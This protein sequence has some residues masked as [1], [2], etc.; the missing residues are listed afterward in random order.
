MPSVLITAFEPYEEWEENSSWLALIELT[1]WFDSGGRVTT[2]RYPANFD[3][4]HKRLRED[5]RAEY[6][7]MLHL[8]Q[9]PG[10]PVLTLESVGLNLRNDGTALFTG[11]PVA[12]QSALPLTRWESKLR[13]AGIPAKVSHHAGTYLC[14]ATLFATHHLARELGVNTQAAFIHVPLAPAQVAKAEK[15]LASISTP[16]AAAGLAIIL[17]DLLGAP[18]M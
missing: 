11:G 5:L 7:V 15:P 14:N 1:N 16:L 3:T 6:D 12:Y 9:L 18:K 17:E 10:A 4:V 8:G 13:E 2:R